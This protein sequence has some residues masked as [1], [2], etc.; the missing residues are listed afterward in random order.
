MRSRGSITAL[1]V[2]LLLLPLTVL[3]SDRARATARFADVQVL[4]PVAWLPQKFGVRGRYSNAVPQIG[5]V[6]K[7][8]AHHPKCVPLRSC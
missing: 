1:S 2:A 6:E 8:P 5:R 3:K 7:L 4:A